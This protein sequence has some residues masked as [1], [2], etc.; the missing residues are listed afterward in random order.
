MEGR[1]FPL[2]IYGASEIFPNWRFTV[3]IKVSSTF[4]ALL[5]QPSSGIWKKEFEMENF[6]NISFRSRFRFGSCHGLIRWFNL[7]SWRCEIVHKHRDDLCRSRKLQREQQNVHKEKLAMEIFLLDLIFYSLAH[8]TSVGKFYKSFD[9][10][11]VQPNIRRLASKTLI[12]SPWVWKQS[13]FY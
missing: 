2:H 1:N 13:A 10:L 3:C 5:L 4:H 12:W 11:D 9:V 8:P 6:Q 7:F